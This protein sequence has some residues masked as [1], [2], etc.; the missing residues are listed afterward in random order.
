[1]NPLDSGSYTH[2][3]VQPPTMNR[4]GRRLT[5]VC[6]GL[7]A[8]AGTAAAHGGGL[9]DGAQRSATVPTWLFLT[10]GGGVIGAS[11]VLASF[12]TDRAFI[13]R[14]HGWRRGG[15]LPAEGVLE[16][17]GR[18]VGVLGLL[19]VLAVGFLGPAEPMS[20][21]AVLV[22]WAGWWSGYA[23]STYL[24]GNTWPVLNPWRS[25]T[26]P[27]PSLERPYPQRLGAWP[28]VVG[29]LALVWLEVVS[30][31]ADDPQ[32]L[33][34]VV[35][36]YTLVTLSGAVVFGEHRW[37]G[38]V[39]PVSRVFRYFGRVAPLYYD[40]GVRLRLP[41]AGLDESKFVTGPAE[42]GFVVAVLWAT[43]FDGLVATPAWRR[44]AVAV[45]EA[46]VPAHLLY[47]LAM[48]AGYLAF[49]GSYRLAVRYSKRHAR[50]YVPVET[51]ARRFAPPLLAIAAGYHAAHFAGYL[52]ELSPTLV[53]TVLSPLSPP[54]PVAVVLPGWFGGLELA[55]VILGHLLAIWVAHA[56]AYDVF[57]GKLQAIRSQYAV[58][59]A[60]VLYTMF[61]LWIVSQPY[62]QPP[63]VS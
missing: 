20:N 15:R 35:V 61:S 32:L 14:V 8:L 54:P 37:F 3:D 53:G 13:R 34:T 31:L 22:V 33:A 21:A 63:Y 38:T 10:T 30:P 58:V 11:F 27:L 12:V 46:G 55:L 28:S 17:A 48:G 40:D 41:G 45:V 7:L 25:L 18:T 57:P 56:A 24:V 43:T 29:L 51:L 9:S 44:L 1:M 4:R 47:P 2:P 39:D 36:G 6:A 60:M 59:L 5:L 23:M 16:L 26:R 62:A 19:F 50:T 52:L 49:L 42:M